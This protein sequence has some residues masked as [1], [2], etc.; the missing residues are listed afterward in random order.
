MSE[1]DQFP[2]PNSR[3]C[4]WYYKGA[5]SLE[6]RIAMVTGSSKGGVLDLTIFG[7]NTKNLVL[8]SGVR[9]KDDP[10]HKTR[11]THAQECGSWDYLLGED[12]R[13]VVSAPTS[14]LADEDSIP[15][16]PPGRPR[17][18]QPQ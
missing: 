1:N 16:R 4:F 2:V 12:P 18:L 3:M 13:V 6:P 11:P 5:L 15:R 9:H 14:M 7:R 10:Y 8:A 17:V